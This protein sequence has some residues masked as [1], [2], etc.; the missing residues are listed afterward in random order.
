VETVNGLN[1]GDDGF[2]AAINI[3]TFMI[4]KYDADTIK[5][6]LD[7]GSVIYAKA[8]VDMYHP[9]NIVEY[10]LWYASIW[11]LLEDDLYKIGTYQK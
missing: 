2:G 11:D 3:P 6:S 4:G 5:E 8:H 9:D 1:L 7:D 10:E